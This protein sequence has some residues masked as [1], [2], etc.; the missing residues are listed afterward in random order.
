MRIWVAF[1]LVLAGTA[2]GAATDPLAEQIAQYKKAGEPIEVADFVLALIPDADNAAVELKAVGDALK[3]R[4]P[5]WQAWEKFNDVR[6]PRV[7]PRSSAEPRR[8]TSTKPSIPACG[9]S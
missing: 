6:P 2:A 1:M 4:R 8:I 9:L 7:P 5:A 3:D